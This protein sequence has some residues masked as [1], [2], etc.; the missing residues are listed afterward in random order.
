MPDLGPLLNP[1]SVAVVGAS[2]KPG[3]F[4]A[5]VIRN[6]IDFGYQ[7]SIYGVHPRLTELFGRPCFASLGSVLLDGTRGQAPVSREK[8][9]D[10]V[11][12]FSGFVDDFA[13]TL[14]E[15]DVNPL[16]VTRDDAIV[17]DALVIPKKHCG[18]N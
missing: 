14:A 2:D 7:G 5:Q 16:L 8:L 9:T 12:K 18:P 6:L 4:G 13:E 15:V 1:H 17:V 11:L 3:S 10:A